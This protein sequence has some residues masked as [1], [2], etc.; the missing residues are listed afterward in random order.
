MMLD[1]ACEFLTEVSSTLSSEVSGITLGMWIGF[2]AIWGLFH[3]LAETAGRKNIVYV[4]KPGT[5]LVIILMGLSGGFHHSAGCLRDSF[6]GD[7]QLQSDYHKIVMIGLLFSIAGDI[8]LMLK[9][10]QFILGLLSFLTAHLFYIYAFAQQ[11]TVY[12][13]WG[14]TGG[15]L[16]VSFAVLALLWRKLGDLKLPVLMYI[17][18]IMTMLWFAIARFQSLSPEEEDPWK[19]NF[20][21]KCP[22]PLYAML[23][24]GLF[25]VSDTA[26]AIGKFYGSYPLDTTIVMVTYFSAQFL[27]A[28]STFL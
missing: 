2:A 3:I 25:V 12:P 11:I 24:A 4:F 19:P 23:G 9:D 21:V 14:V 13:D 10:Q 20:G 22:G 8:F 28:L 5:M 15:L 18:A 1:S 16:A 26:L 17:G 7:T 27:I 6:T